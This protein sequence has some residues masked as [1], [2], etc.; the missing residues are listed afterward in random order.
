MELVRELWQNERS[1]SFCLDFFGPFCV[2]TKRAEEQ[3]NKRKDGMLHKQRK[4][5]AWQAKE[6]WHTVRVYPDRRVG[7]TKSKVRGM[8]LCI[9]LHCYYATLVVSPKVK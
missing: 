1:S 6:R 7:T 5:I 9:K 4:E 3:A 8:F 2:K